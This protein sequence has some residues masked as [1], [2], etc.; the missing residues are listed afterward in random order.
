MLIVLLFVGISDLGCISECTSL[1]RLNLSRN[2]IS[3]L[4][5]LAGLN[6]LT[7]LNLS[8]NRIVSLGEYFQVNRV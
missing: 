6:N 8:A 3:K 4:T 7:H 2:D 5:K 1:E